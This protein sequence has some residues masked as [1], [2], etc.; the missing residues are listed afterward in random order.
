MNLICNPY[1]NMFAFPLCP[2]PQSHN[3]ILF[4]TREVSPLL[5]PFQNQRRLLLFLFLKNE[6]KEAKLQNHL[7]KL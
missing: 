4:F 5:S 1:M 6:T 3:K 2:P 7:A